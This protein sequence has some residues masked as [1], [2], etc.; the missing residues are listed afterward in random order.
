MGKLRVR[1]EAIRIESYL[2]IAAVGLIVASCALW[3]RERGLRGRHAAIGALLDGADA[4][5]RRLQECR[6]RMQHLRDMLTVLPEEMSERADSALQA[7][8]KVQAALKD[9]LA[10]RLWIQQH[11]AAASLRE[12]DAARC[13]LEQSGATLQAQLDRLAGI[14]ADL[15]RAQ[16]EARTLKKPG[17]P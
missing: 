11:A 16:T 5:E 17:A 14:A 12:L 13:A 7:D 4:L 8:A 1:N 6:E 10:H 2:V 15:Q 3:L 9:L